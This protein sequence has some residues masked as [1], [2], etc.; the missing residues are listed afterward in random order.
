MHG[1]TCKWPDSRQSC[2]PAGPPGRSRGCPPLQPHY[3]APPL[4]GP[5]LLVVAAATTTVVA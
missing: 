1:Y 4:A 3:P 5:M 2:S